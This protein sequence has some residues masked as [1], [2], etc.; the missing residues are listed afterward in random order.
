MGGTGNLKNNLDKS[1]QDLFEDY[2]KYID[3]DTGKYK[4]TANSPAQHDYMAEHLINDIAL[5]IK[6]FVETNT[7]AI[8]NDNSVSMDNYTALAWSTLWGTDAFAQFL[9][10]TGETE[11]TQKSKITLLN[12]RTSNDCN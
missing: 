12:S 11:D 2:A 10:K 4:S 6:D 8:K 5:G 1:F 9:Q 3:P 7:P